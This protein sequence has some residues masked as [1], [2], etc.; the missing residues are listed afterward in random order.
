MAAEAMPM[1]TK[2]PSRN[3]SICIHSQ[4][5]LKFVPLQHLD[6]LTPPDKLEREI[7]QAFVKVLTDSILRYGLLT[8]LIVTVPDKENRRVVLAGQHRLAACRYIHD[9]NLDPDGFVS[10]AYREVTTAQ[11][12]DRALS[13]TENLT[14]KELTREE[15]LRQMAELVDLE[16]FNFE[17]LNDNGVASRPIQKEFAKKLG[18]STSNF[19]NMWGKYC[20]D[21]HGGKVNYS[22]ADAV[23][24][25]GFSR[26]LAEQ[27]DDPK[28]RKQSAPKPKADKIREILAPHRE[29]A[30]VTAIVPELPPPATDTEA[31]VMGPDGEPVAEESGDD[32]LARAE[33]VVVKLGGRGYFDCRPMILE[34]ARA[35]SESGGEVSLLVVLLQEL[36]AEVDQFLDEA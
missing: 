8:P 2:P 9:N 21:V 17:F 15:R 33:E 36:S 14:R 10:L 35:Y 29:A 32:L 19:S 6:K 22:K 24:M 16:K 30:K 4:Q 23:V 18:L 27:A 3:A 12:M 11:W 20:E 5:P 28:P 31:Y 25:G 1:T 34:L 7:D 26:W 13:I